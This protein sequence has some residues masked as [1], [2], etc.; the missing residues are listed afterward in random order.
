VVHRRGPVGRAGARRRLVPARRAAAR[1][2]RGDPAAGGEQGVGEPDDRAADRL[3]QGA[4]QG[5]ARHRE[6][7]GGDPLEAPAVAGHAFADPPALVPGQD[8]RRRSRR[9]RTADAGRA[10]RHVG[11]R[12]AGSLAT[13]GQ[14]NQIP[15]SIKVVGRFA[16]VRLFLSGVERLDRAV[17]VTGVDIKRAENAEDSASTN[18]LEVDLTGR[19]FMANKGVAPQPAAATTTTEGSTG[20]S[21]EGSTAS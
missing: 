10:D 16:N 12:R 7:D 20:T 1:D 9:R 4:V 3:A 8:Q 18:A 13:P 11:G 21:P 19:T 5:P 17:L 6:A 2:R 15:L 14:V